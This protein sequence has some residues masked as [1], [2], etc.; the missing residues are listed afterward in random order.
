M[1]EA[2][3]PQDEGTQVRPDDD[4]SRS[5]DL[6]RATCRHCGERIRLAR[7]TNRWTHCRR[8]AK[9]IKGMGCREPFPANEYKERER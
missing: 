8:M 5:D 9:T 7:L 6:A 2:S 3:K 1:G 4:L